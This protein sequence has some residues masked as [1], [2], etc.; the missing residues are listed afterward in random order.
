MRQFNS[1]AR[2]STEATERHHSATLAAPKLL[3][4]IR[5]LAARRAG[6]AV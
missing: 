3:K 4:F 1:D 6:R 5:E 2:K